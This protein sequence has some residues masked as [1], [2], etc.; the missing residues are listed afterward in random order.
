MMPRTSKRWILKLA[1][2]LTFVTL[3]LI[4]TAPH[5]VQAGSPNPGVL[6]P[7]SY[8]YG[9]SYGEWS[10]AWWQWVFNLPVSTDGTTT[11]PLFVAGDIDCSYGQ[12]GKVWFLGGTYVVNPDP[13]GN[14]AG[15]ATRA[16][17]ILDCTHFTEPTLKDTSRRC[18]KGFRTQLVAGRR[19]SNAAAFHCR[20]H[21]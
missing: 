2:L 7:Q 1:T 17:T 10:A 5:R 15:T 16:C 18:C 4:G 11:H 19:G 6:P 14:F 8:P 9:R 12:S 21:Q 20:L 3:V 13:N